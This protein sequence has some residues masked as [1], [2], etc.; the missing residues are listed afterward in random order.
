MGKFRI[1]IFLTFSLISIFFWSQLIDLITY[2]LP[3]TKYVYIAC[4]HEIYCDQNF[5]NTT[6]YQIL[7]KK[8]PALYFFLFLVRFQFF[9][10]SID[11]SKQ[12]LSI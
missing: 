2:Y 12:V 3:I 9:L 8:N 5:K 7:Q 1:R 6:F 11:R 4:I 10:V